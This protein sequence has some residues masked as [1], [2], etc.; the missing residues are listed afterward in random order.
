MN[1][2]S[3]IQVEPESPQSNEGR[4]E[5]RWTPTP[6]DLTIT[7]RDM[8]FRR[9]R[10]A[11]QRWWLNGDPVATAWHNAL[12]ATFPRGEAFFIESV[13]AFRDGAPP[14]L[15]AAIRAFVAQEINHTREHIVFN[16]AVNEAGY[17]LTRIDA[18]VEETMAMTKGRPEIV[19]LAAT[20]ALEHYTA[21]MAHEV[22]ANPQ[23]LAGSDPEL[24]RMWHWHGTEEIEHKGVA[25]DTFLHATRDWPRIKRWRLKSLMM[26]VVTRNFLTNRVIDTLDLLAQDGFTGWKIKA[27]LAWYLL[28][29]PGILRRIFPDWL[30]Y[31]LPR[32]HPWNHDNRA[33]IADAAGGPS[34]Y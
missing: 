14:E 34:P 6:D 25:Y 5:P 8:R 26:L 19:N 24:A 31:F 21:M 13:K 20:I 3:S 9:G 15:D 1:A 16:K 10:Q 29:N 18:H 2:H 22:L 33:L 23:H 27:R 4:K 30:A 11:G 12:S 17:D 32:F 7:V 28:G